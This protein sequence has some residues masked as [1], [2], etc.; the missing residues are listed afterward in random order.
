ML[1]VLLF[2]SLILRKCQQ[3]GRTALSGR[4]IA[5]LSLQSLEYLGTIILGIKGLVSILEFQDRQVL[6]E[7]KLESDFILV[8]MVVSLMSASYFLLHHLTN[9]YFY[10]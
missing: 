4:E 1:L 8:Y 9:E 7:Q 5:L 3:T 2:P 6:L 10:R